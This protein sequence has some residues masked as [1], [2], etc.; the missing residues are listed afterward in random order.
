M[1][2]LRGDVD[3]VLEGLEYCLSGGDD[4]TDQRLQHVFTDGWSG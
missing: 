3:E 2:G 1:I 4:K